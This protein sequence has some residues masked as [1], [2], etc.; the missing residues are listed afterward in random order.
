ME[1]SEQWEP[2]RAVAK[3]L[4]EIRK[5]RGLTAEQLADR[6]TEQGVPWQR[7]TVAKLENGSRENVTIAEWLA[8]AYVLDVAPIHLLVPTDAPAGDVYQVTPTET[9]TIG[10]VRAWVRGFEE[11]PGTDRRKFY[12]SVPEVEFG[13]REVDPERFEWVWS[14][15]KYVSRSMGRLYRRDDG[16]PVFELELPK[17]SGG[18]G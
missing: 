7:S 9:A 12:A 6:L 18:D 5:R 14:V 3:R 8:L 1:Q 16:T 11:L 15:V 13:V 10:D 4:R 2:T 17:G